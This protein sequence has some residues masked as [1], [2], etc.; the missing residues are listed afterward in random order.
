VQG[1]RAQRG[2]RP[3]RVGSPTP[4]VRAAAPAERSPASASSS[5]RAAT[6][7]WDRSDRTRRPVQP[8][9]TNLRAAAASHPYTGFEGSTMR[10][11]I[12]AALLA[13][14][15]PAVALAV[16]E[17]PSLVDLAKAACKSEKAQ[18]GQEHVHAHVPD[19]QRVHGDER[20]RRQARR[21]RGDRPQERRQGMQGRAGRGPGRVHEEVRHEQERQERVRQVRFRQGP[22]CDRAGDRGSRERRQDVQEAEGRAEGDL[23]SG[24][25]HEEERLRQVRVRDGQGIVTVSAPG[26]AAGISAAAR[27]RPGWRESASRLSRRAA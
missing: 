10:T 20:V 27:S 1:R 8:S 15:V 3:L 17:G 7:N 19:Q 4:E 16:D 22:P 9:P 2:N 23:R 18:M 14:A 12:L 11:L 25:R 5:R 26:R 24:L 13:L 21:P 6:S